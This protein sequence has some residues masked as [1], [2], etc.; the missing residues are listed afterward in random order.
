MLPT[1]L[2]F[3]SA[4]SHVSDRFAECREN[5]L[6]TPPILPGRE[7]IISLL[8]QSCRDVGKL[9][10]YSANLAE[11]WENYLTTPPILPGRE[12]II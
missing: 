10:R 5:Y 1:T 6:T 8:R 2:R 4:F 3:G 11:T 9:S 7:K 12:K